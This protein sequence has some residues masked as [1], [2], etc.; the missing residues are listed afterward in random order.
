MSGQWVGVF[1]STLLLA[2]CGS[3]GQGTTGQSNGGQP[4]ILYVADIAHG[5]I[6]G[7]AD[8]DPAAGAMLAGRVISG[9]TGLGGNLAYDESRDSLYASKGGTVVV[10]DQASLASG[11]VM[12]SRTLTPS[13]GPFVSLSLLLDKSTDQLYVGANR[14]S[15]DGVVLVFAGASTL[16]GS[17]A[18]DRT[19]VVPNGVN[20][21]TLDT[22]RSIL[23]V[24]G[25]IIGVH[26]YENADTA[27]GTLSP[28]R[29]IGGFT[30]ATGLSIDAGRDRLYVAD[31]F[32]GIRFI[33]DASSPSSAASP[34][35]VPIPNAHFATVDAT[36]DRL[37]VGAYEKAY[38]LDN[39]SA[40]VTGTLPAS[41]VGALAPAG[42]SIA[43]FAFP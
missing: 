5:A 31:V 30:S 1:A 43:G 26:V 16:S 12:P 22:S 27:S 38:I 11:T 28:A 36:N 41:A 40:L 32:A 21:F 8:A 15:G 14:Q 23:Y 37:Y 10:F 42:S 29:V 24:L 2:G 7:F 33:P 25:A 6:G 3:S 34:G 19:M 39:A 17:K 20:T 35:A 9:V 4:S 13:G 18:P